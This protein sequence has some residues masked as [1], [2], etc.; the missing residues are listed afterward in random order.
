MASQ[1]SVP[2]QGG[3]TSGGGSGHY[4][5]VYSKLKR[6]TEKDCSSAKEYLEVSISILVVANSTGQNWTAIM[7]ILWRS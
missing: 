5:G 4:Q 1:R 2:F 7:Q 3:S 6:S